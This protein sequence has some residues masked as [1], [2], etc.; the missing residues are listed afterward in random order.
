M[1]RVGAVRDLQNNRIGPLGVINVLG[2][3]LDAGVLLA[4]RVAKYPEVAQRVAI[5]VVGIGIK[6]HRQRLDALARNRLGSRRRRRVGSAG[7][8]K[9]QVPYVEVAR[10]PIVEDR[11][12]AID[13]AE[14]LV[15]RIVGQLKDLAA[16]QVIHKD[17]HVAGLDAV[18]VNIVAGRPHIFPQGTVCG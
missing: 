9:G 5:G 7:D 6:L 1:N 14:H 2:I 4:P 13:C 16:G 3:L 11:P 12:G 10:A 17:V 8:G 18:P 15:T